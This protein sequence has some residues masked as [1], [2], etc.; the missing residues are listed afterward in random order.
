MKKYNQL[1]K[2]GQEKY[3]GKSPRFILV[4]NIIFTK[5]CLRNMRRYDSLREFGKIV[6]KHYAILRQDGAFLI[7]TSMKSPQTQTLLNSKIKVV[8]HF[9]SSQ[10]IVGAL[11]DQY[12]V[13]LMYNIFNG[14]DYVTT[15]LERRNLSDKE[16]E[17]MDDFVDKNYEGIVQC[18]S[19]IAEFEGILFGDGESDV[20]GN[21][22]E[23][24]VCFESD[25]AQSSDYSE[26]NFLKFNDQSLIVKGSIDE[27][28]N[29]KEDLD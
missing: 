7:M 27:D 21:F 15:S 6:N 20:E 4:K 17:L 8:P 25:A 5:K 26:D 16:K 3:F 23:G 14:V 11:K 12:V 24:L 28:V 1:Q 19:K 22:E 13:G 10:N 29:T 2:L 9:I 18:M